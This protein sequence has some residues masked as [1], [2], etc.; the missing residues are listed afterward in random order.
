[1][2][3]YEACLSAA[4]RSL[5]GNNHLLDQLALLSSNMAS[6]MLEV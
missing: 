3:G 1:M 5:K 4:L 2:F 6:L